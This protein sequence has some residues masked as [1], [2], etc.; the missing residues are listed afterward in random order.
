MPSEA[1]AAHTAGSPL[2]SATPALQLPRTPQ[3]AVL[4]GEGGTRQIRVGHPQGWATSKL[5]P[6]LWRTLGLRSDLLR[7]A[8]RAQ[9]GT[10]VMYSTYPPHETG[11]ISCHLDQFEAFF[12]S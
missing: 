6:C 11:H 3:T 10:G 4:I 7:Q 5:S 9:A 12:S 2:N 1:V 8:G